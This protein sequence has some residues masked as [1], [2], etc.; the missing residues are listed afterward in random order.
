MSEKQWC[1]NLGGGGEEG[2]GEV[3]VYLYLQHHD[4]DDEDFI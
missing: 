4:D 1:R 3:A 2:L